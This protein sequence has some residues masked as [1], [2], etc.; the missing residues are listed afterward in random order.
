MRKLRGELD[1]LAARVA[2][3]G[4]RPSLACLEWIDPLMS[5]G[6]WVP[7][8]AELAGGRNLLGIPGRHSPW[9]GWDELIVADADVIAVMPCGFDMERTRGEMTTLTGDPRWQSLRAVRDSRVYLTDGNQFFNRPGPR[10]VDSARIL[11]EILHPDLCPPTLEGGGWVHF[12]PGE[13]TA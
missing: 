1:E 2:H 6:N 8:L 4:T 12:E 7:E 13:P 9:L 3:A 11:A 10:L 5:A